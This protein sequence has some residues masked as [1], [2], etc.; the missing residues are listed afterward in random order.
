MAGF[1]S[2]YARAI[3]AFP[4]S[5]FFKL[6]RTPLAYLTL[7]VPA[8]VFAQAQ[9]STPGSFAV[10]PSGRCSY[11]ASSIS[12]HGDRRHKKVG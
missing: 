5:R 11:C 2:V 10:S 8:L 6:L 7:L 1:R 3:F 9:M 12:T 4:I